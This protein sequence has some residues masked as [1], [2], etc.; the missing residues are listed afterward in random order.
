MQEEGEKVGPKLGSSTHV[1]LQFSYVF[2]YTGQFG[3]L[4]T[5]FSVEGTV[6]DVRLCPPGSHGTWIQEQDEWE[7]MAHRVSTS[8]VSGPVWCEEA[9]S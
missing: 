3:N 7:E 8:P 1:L 2:F 9:A 5:T 6:F 4:K